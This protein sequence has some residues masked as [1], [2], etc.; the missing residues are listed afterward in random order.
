MIS[1]TNIPYQKQWAE[2]KSCNLNAK[3][4]ELRVLKGWFYRRWTRCGYKWNR[5]TIHTLSQRQAAATVKAGKR[6]AELENDR[7]VTEDLISTIHRLIIT[8][9]DDHC[10][11][12][13]LLKKIKNVIFGV[14]KYRGEVVPNVKRLYFGARQ[15]IANSAT[16]I[17]SFKP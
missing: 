2:Q 5:G 12:G 15:L 16:M 13:V 1:L 7:P 17:H 14:P 10:P 3:Q 11:L 8:T 9:D 6:I 4:Q